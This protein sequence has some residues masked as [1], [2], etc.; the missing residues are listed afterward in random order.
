MNFPPIFPAVFPWQLPL[1]FFFCLYKFDNVSRIMGVFVLLWLTYSLGI[2][3]SRSIH[4]VANNKIS[5]FLKLNIIPPYVY[6]TFYLSIHLSVDRLFSMSF[7][8]LYS[9]S[10][11][12]QSCNLPHVL[13][14]TWAW[15]LEM[16]SWI[17]CESYPGLTQLFN[18]AGRAEPPVPAR[19]LGFDSI[20][21]FIKSRLVCYHEITLKPLGWPILNANVCA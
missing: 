9:S 14:S 15:Q 3:S 20:S 1:F 12:F 11:C 19:E 2:I 21:W 10:E 6:S 4:V 17:C 8:L 13:I 16:G 5:F 18:F 7:F